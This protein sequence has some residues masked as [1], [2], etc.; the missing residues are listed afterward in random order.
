MITLDAS[1]LI[2]HLDPENVHHVLATELLLA[3]LTEP[4]LVHPITLAEVLVGG[5]RIGR[6]R[7]MDAD[8]RAMGIQLVELDDQ[9]PLRLAQL[10]V[11]TRLKLPDCCVLDAAMSHD[12]RLATFDRALSTA[13]VSQG[14]PVLP[15]P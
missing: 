1:V 8:L 15:V 14:L 3:A 9:Q 4:L 5:A 6:E 13:A 11:T 2:A 12:A 7:Q 10:R